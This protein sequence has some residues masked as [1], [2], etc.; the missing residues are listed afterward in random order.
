MAYTCRLATDALLLAVD[1]YPRKPDVVFEPLVAP[2]DPEDH[3]FAALK[4][5]KIDKKPPRARK[6]KKG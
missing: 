5:L 6:P 3:P 1:P 2:E 4:A